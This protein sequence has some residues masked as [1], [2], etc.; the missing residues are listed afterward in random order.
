MKKLLLLILSIGAVNSAM[1]QNAGFYFNAVSLNQNGT[2]TEVTGAANTPLNSFNGSGILNLTGAVSKTYKN[3]SGNVCGPVLNYRVYE[4]GSIPGSFSQLN[5]PFF[6]EYPAAGNSN[7]GDQ[8]WRGN[9]ATPVNLLTGRPNGN[10]TLEVY[11]VTTGNLNGNNFCPD[12][13]YD[14]NGG[15]NFKYNFTINSPLPVIL[16][17]FSGKAVDRNINLSWETASE[18][19]NDFFQ[20]QKSADL[21]SWEAV[22][23][24]KGKGTIEAKTE[25]NFVDEMPQTG[26][27][28]YYRLK[29]VD[30]NGK[31][32]YSKSIA[33]KMNSNPMLQVFPNPTTEFVQVTGIETPT[34]LQLIDSKGLVVEERH[35]DKNERLEVKNRNSGIYFIRIFDAASS[36]SKR[37]VVQ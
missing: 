28:H 15:S 7:S 23:E 18:Q 29:Q 33:V 25:Y 27:T 2:P 14:S 3:G 4:V 6:S 17:K 22:G 11:Y 31:Y 1:A 16:S 21:K 13:F 10:Y 32:E 35:I 12:T 20:V 37:I 9:F 19:E 30:F 24:V 36:Q 34:T 26:M 5:L 8:T